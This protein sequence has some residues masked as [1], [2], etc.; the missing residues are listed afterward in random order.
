[1]ARHWASDLLKQER[2]AKVGIKAK[3]KKAGWDYR[4]L[5]S[6]VILKCN[7]PG[8]QET[9]EGTKAVAHI[10]LPTRL[11]EGYRCPR[12]GHW[13]DR[14]LTLVKACRSGYL[15]GAARMKAAYD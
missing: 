8:H 7:C 2:T 14:F 11:P 1:M 6:L 12:L 3:R 5:Q 4:Y 10:P 9:R 13:A 15:P